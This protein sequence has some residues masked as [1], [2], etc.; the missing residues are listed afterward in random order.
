MDQFL[1]NKV[2]NIL[3]YSF[4]LKF[5]AE[6]FLGKDSHLVESLKKYHLPFSKVQLLCVLI[7]NM[8]YPKNSH[9][10]ECIKENKF[11][12]MKT[13][14]DAKDW[15]KLQISIG[16]TKSFNDYQSNKDKFDKAARAAG[17]AKIFVEA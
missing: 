4:Y 5:Y 8:M 16:L 12:E 13:P 7:Q 14:Q 10:L 9:K 1:K 15:L 3:K 6:A 2:D 11:C 17:L